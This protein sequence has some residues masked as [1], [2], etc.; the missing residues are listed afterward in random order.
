[1]PALVVNGGLPPGRTIDFAPAHVPDLTLDPFA[2]AIAF[3]GMSTDTLVV[4][5]Q[6]AL[7]RLGFRA[8]T[9]LWT[10]GDPQRIV[11]A[12]G[13]QKIRYLKRRDRVIDATSFASVQ[14]TFGYLQ[15][16]GLTLALIGVGGLLLYLDTRQRERVVAYAFVRRMG[17]S[18]RGH[19][20]SVLIEVALTLGSGYVLGTIVAAVAGRLI[21][22]R[23]DPVPAIA[24]S[25]VVR[26][27]LTS[28]AVVGA[29]TL[30]VC[31]GGAW[32]AQRSADR[33]RSAEVL[34]LEV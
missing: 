12:Y 33:A 24:P 19:R 25:P 3:P 20:R 22:S 15:A 9:E 32:L 31:W 28:F 6:A 17:L 16:L 34:R 23:I 11:D 10:K 8:T 29:V 2:G 13:D 1:V 7:E 30:L 18:R 14:W 27:P 5:D 21:L 26:Y 4:V